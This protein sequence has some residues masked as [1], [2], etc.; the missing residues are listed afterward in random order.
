MT[1]RSPAPR[2]QQISDLKQWDLL[3][4]EIIAANPWNGLRR[5]RVRLPDG[6]IVE[7]YFVSLRPHLAVVFALTADGQVL[8]VR[9]YKHGA[10]E[11]TLELPAGTFRTGEAADHARR[12]LR[13][14]RIYA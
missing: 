2:R 9:Q 1:R 13:E 4:S 7:D 14:R 12:E 11:I 3:S 10:G 5:D 8:L 6:S